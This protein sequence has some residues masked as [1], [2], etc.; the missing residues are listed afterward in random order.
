MD[1]SRYSFAKVLGAFALVALSSCSDPVSSQSELTFLEGS[2]AQ[3]SFAE[4]C[5]AWALDCVPPEKPAEP[6]VAVAQVQAAFSVG[7]VFLNGGSRLGFSASDWSSAPITEAFALLLQG[8][9]HNQVGQKLIDVGFKSFV[10]EGKGIAR[11]AFEAKNYKGKSGLVWSVP[12]QEMTAALN[13][14]GEMLTTGLVVS[15][16][17]GNQS[18]NVAKITF[19]NTDMLTIESDVFRISDVPAWFVYREL[20]TGIDVPSF[21]KV[22]PKNFGIVANR[23]VSFVSTTQQTILADSALIS[24][25]LT[26]FDALVP[27]PAKGFWHDSVKK[28]LQRV[29]SAK[30]EVG[31]GELRVMGNL[32]EK[33]SLW[34]DMVGS[35]VVL[36]I[37]K[38]FSVTFPLQTSADRVVMSFKGIAGKLNL[39]GP[40][41]PGFELSVVEFTGEK[42]ILKGVPVIGEYSV[43]I[44]KVPP[45]GYDL[46]CK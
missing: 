34:C 35:P 20:A 36:E 31:G 24:S 16:A 26:N 2:P 21:Q 27:K 17:Q 44:T 42:M 1:Y 15:N 25:L 9:L 14:G 4:W 28:M 30:V 13:G 41:K 23:L 18:A 46:K 29:N 8:P 7:N 22:P 6:H 32:K 11:L 5:S 38:D 10:V 39:A 19:S 12:S 37:R 33:P 3:I 45:D 40:V 43:D